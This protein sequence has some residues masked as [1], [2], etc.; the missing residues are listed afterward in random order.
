MKNTKKPILDVISNDG[1]NQKAMQPSPSRSSLSFNILPYKE[2]V[3]NTEFTLE[4]AINCIAFP[5][6]HYIYI[7]LSGLCNVW[8][9]MEKAN[10]LTD[11]DAA[12][13]CLNK[14]TEKMLEFYATN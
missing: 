7:S 2:N 3:I 12:K 8:F 4:D 14:L 9:A 1:S 13:I 5:K 11:N 6:D 10:G